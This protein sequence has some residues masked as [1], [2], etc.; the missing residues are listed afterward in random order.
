MKI[1]FHTNTINYRG[2]TVALTDYARYNQEIL[3]HESVIAYCKSFGTEK[4]FGTQEE[5]LDKLKKKF[6]VMRL[7]TLYLSV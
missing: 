3:G 2:T 7:L 5:V 1:M 4:D 6:T